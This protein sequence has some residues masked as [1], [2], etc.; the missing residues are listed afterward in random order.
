MSKAKSFFIAFGQFIL[1]SV[2]W[3]I[4]SFL[5][6]YVAFVIIESFTIDESIISIFSFVFQLIGLSLTFLAFRRNVR[7]IGIGIICALIL[8]LIGFVVYSRGCSV[9]GLPFPLWMILWC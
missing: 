2:G 7:W 6:I 4:L 1:G 8:N 9:P 5:I 3:L